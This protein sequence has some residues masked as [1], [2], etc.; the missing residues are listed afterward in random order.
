MSD[1]NGA[2]IAPIELT[3]VVPVKPA[4][5]KTL[6]SLLL[7]RELARAIAAF[8]KASDDSSAFF[9]TPSGKLEVFSAARV[10]FFLPDYEKWKQAVESLREQ[11]TA[12]HEE[13]HLAVYSALTE[14]E[15]SPES[16]K[17]LVSSFLEKNGILAV[18]PS[19][20]KTRGGLR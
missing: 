19:P 15:L 1:S 13:M 11:L 12:L 5:I 9:T 10:G 2:T 8:F 16:M 14:S 3:G 18:P 20:S 4:T 17:F 7:K 6:E